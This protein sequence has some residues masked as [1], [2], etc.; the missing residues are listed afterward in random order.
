MKTELE[1][2]ETTKDNIIID[3]F[4]DFKLQ[5]VGFMPIEFNYHNDWN[6]LMEVVEKIESLNYSTEFNFIPNYG[7]G[8]KIFSGGAEVIKLK[9]YPTKIEAMY[10]AIID[11]I[12]W[13]NKTK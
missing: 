4:N 8:L 9:F 5:R 2:E 3:A 13:Y 10:K 1:I 7:H 12:K 6:S 11:F